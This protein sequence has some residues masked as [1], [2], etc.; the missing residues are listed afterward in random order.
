MPLYIRDEAI[1]EQVGKLAA[2]LKVSKT[3]AVR[4]ALRAALKDTVEAVP[5]QEK[6]EAFW[7]D[8]PVPAQT[9]QVADKA[10]FDDLSG[11]L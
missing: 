4:F 9:G 11:G 6:M 7:R 2:R 8:N 5:L 3:E 10:F 1:D